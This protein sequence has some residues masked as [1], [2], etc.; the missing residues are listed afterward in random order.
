MQV[1]THSAWHDGAGGAGGMPTH[2]P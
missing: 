2:A 1:F